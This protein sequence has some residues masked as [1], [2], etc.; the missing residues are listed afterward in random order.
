MICHICEEMDYLSKGEELI[1]TDLGEEYLREI[2]L[3]C[4]KEKVFQLIR[5]GSASKGVEFCLILMY[6]FYVIYYFDD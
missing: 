4:T 2:G 5:N 3:L 1:N 6:F